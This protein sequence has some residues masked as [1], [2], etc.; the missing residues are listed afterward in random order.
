MMLVIIIRDVCQIKD[1]EEAWSHGAGPSRPGIERSCSFSAFAKP[2]LCVFRRGGRGGQGSGLG[3]LCCRSQGWAGPQQSLAHAK[4]DG[5]VP[6]SPS[7]AGGSVCPKALVHPLGGLCA[8][9]NLG[10]SPWM[11][12]VHP[13]TQGGFCAPRD[14]SESSQGCCS[15]V[16]VHPP[17]EVSLLLKILVHPLGRVLC[18]PR[19]LCILL[20]GFCAPQGLGAPSWEVSLHPKV[21]VH[22]PGKVLCT[23][24]SW[25]ILLGRFCAPKDLGASPQGFPVHPKV[26]AQPRGRFCAPQDLGAPPGWFLCPHPNPGSFTGCPSR[27]CS[28]YLWCDICNIVYFSYVS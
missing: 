20:G 8:P 2:I 19:S 26:L 22:P 23:P 15:V 5:P 28:L 7:P 13:E 3:G 27:D 12:S 6:L 25:C 17:Q 9:Q 21:L 1:E 4:G 18:T 11:S 10:V 24:R 14:L 16:S